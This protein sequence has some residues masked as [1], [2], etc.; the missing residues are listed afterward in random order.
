[1]EEPEEIQD[2][3][4]QKKKDHVTMAIMVVVFAI[5]MYVIYIM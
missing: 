1:M 5:L 3:A 4:E 2:S